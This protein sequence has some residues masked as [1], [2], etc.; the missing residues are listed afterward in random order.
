MKR[1]LN[2]LPASPRKR[3]E[4]IIEIAKDNGLELKNAPPPAAAI[5]RTSQTPENVRVAVVQHYEDDGVSYQCPGRRDCRVKVQ[6]NGVTEEK[7][8]RY[9]LMTVKEAHSLFL[10]ENQGMVIKLSK[11]AELRPAYVLLQ[12]ATPHWVCTCIYHENVMFLLKALNAKGVPVQKDFRG[13][14]SQVVCDQ[15]SAECMQSGCIDCPGLSFIQLS[16]SLANEGCTWEKWDKVNGRFTLVP[17][18]GTVLD[19]V[20]KLQESLPSFLNHTFVKRQQSEAFK[21]ARDFIRVN[22]VLIQVD[23]A[24]NYSC[25]FQH[26]IQS[27][28]WSQKLVSIFTAVAWYR[29]EEGA[30]V[31]CKSFAFVSDW[32]EHDKYSVHVGLQH[33][34]GQLLKI[35]PNFSKAVI[36]SD[37]AASQFKQRFSMC[38]LTY[39]AEAL[40]MNF[41]W[42]FFESYHGKGAVDA[43]GGKVK[44]IAWTAARSK[45]RVACAADIVKVCAQKGCSTTVME[46]PYNE[47]P[48]CKTVLDERWNNIKAIPN[49][50]S[51]HHVKVTGLDKILYAA[52]TNGFLAIRHAHCFR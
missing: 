7:S 43:V 6:L 44:K 4:L 23:Y 46:I 5:G 31:Q 41:E 40:N 42:N 9:M 20:N 17:D 25:K 49:T 39:L 21:E 14:I 51:M 1:L 24:E 15:T 33:L 50:Q 18:K 37:G 52:M 32:A 30:E 11:F 16:D 36:F 47:V 2:A 10:K 19:C 28:H 29:P 22:E 34:F 13:F 27:A 3:R 35:N 38:N 8:V 48:D 26:E 45:V 12:D